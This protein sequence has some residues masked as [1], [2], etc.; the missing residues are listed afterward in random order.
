MVVWNAGY[1]QWGDDPL[2]IQAHADHGCSP[3][4]VFIGMFG[5]TPDGSAPQDVRSEDGQAHTA[6]QHIE[7]CRM[8]V[9]HQVPAQYDAKDKI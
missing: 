7:Y 4:R 2:S 5:L 3:T 8:C 9:E 6:D 1:I